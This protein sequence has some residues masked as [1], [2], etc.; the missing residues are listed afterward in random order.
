VLDSSHRHDRPHL[1]G[2]ADRRNLLHEQEIFKLEGPAGRDGSWVFKGTSIRTVL[3]Y[4]GMGLLLVVAIVVL[5][6]EI[7][8][9]IRAIDSWI[10]GFGPLGV[11]AFI[12]FFVLATS[13]F[14][15]E[16][17]LSIMAGALFGM[18]E[19]LA[20]VVIGGIAAATV[21]FLLSRRILRPR[22]E[23][24]LASKP[25]LAAIRSAVM[26]SEIRIQTLLRLT[27]LNPATL[28][29]L[30]GASGIR[31]PVFLLASLAFLPHQVVEVYFGFAGRHIAKI[32]SRAGQIMYIRDAVVLGG[33]IMSIIALV[34]IALTARRAVAAAIAEVGEALPEHPGSSAR[35]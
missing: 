2:E 15:P 9:H 31:F 3:L 10:A 33:L 29:Y 30:F 6:K 17:L 5:G 35:N 16:T 21:Q 22:I 34:F 23:K 7:G 19:G 12:G 13:F 28:N 4:A 20:A 26:Q 27:P 18:M 24:S 1:P 14:V 25:P 11:L 32:A 8:H